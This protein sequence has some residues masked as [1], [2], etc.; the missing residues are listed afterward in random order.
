MREREGGD[1]DRG[2]RG[3]E[4]ERGRKTIRKKVRGRLRREWGKEGKGAGG[5][6]GRQKKGS[7][8]LNNKPLITQ[9]SPLELT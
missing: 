5:G 3:R 7:S 9:T 1:R 2:K 8:R 6:G 4:R